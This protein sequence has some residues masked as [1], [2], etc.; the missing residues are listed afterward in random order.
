[1]NNQIIFIN[2]DIIIDSGGE[3]ILNNSSIVFTSSE[4]KN[5]IEVRSG[6]LLKLDNNS[7]V[8]SSISENNYYIKINR[9]GVFHSNNSEINYAGF[10]FGFDYTK[11]GVWINSDNTS[12]ENTYFKSNYMGIYL[13][14]TNNTSITNCSFYENYIGAYFSSSSNISIVNSKIS[15]SKNA[16]AIIKSS[17]SVNF[18]NMIIRDN[19]GEVL[20]TDSH[21]ITFYKSTIEHNNGGVRL[22]NI[23]GVL[24]LKNQVTRNNDGINI[25]DS[26]KIIIQ[27]NIITQNEGFAVYLINSLNCTIMRNTLKS[28]Q[29]GFSF[30]GIQNLEVVGNALLN[31]SFVFVNYTKETFASVQFNSSN[32]INGLPI[33]MIFNLNDSKVHNLTAGQLFIMFSN[34]ITIVSSNITGIEIYK[35]SEIIILES[36]TSKSDYGAYI[37]RS[38][39]VTLSESYF[40]DNYIGIYLAFDNTTQ[41]RNNTIRNNYHYGIFHKKSNNTIAYLNFFLDNLHHIHDDTAIFWDNTTIGNY[42]DDYTGIDKNNDGIG[43]VAYT[44]DSDSED[45]F[46]IV[47]PD[48]LSPEINSITQYPENP[49][50]L[51]D[52]R[53]EASI[54]D[55]A[56]VKVVILSLTNSSTWVN[57]SMN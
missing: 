25:R 40:E 20:A 37:R 32:I 10:A 35:A 36:A 15:K 16:G 12:M 21:N 11:S 43:D 2:S 3:L 4:L 52:V 18:N 13:E 27:E 9:Y 6:G 46:P 17:E 41:I 38:H 42:W 47:L 22:E 23:S 44:I 26:N 14:S 51:D 30:D 1:M 7:I 53:I 50:E 19:G 48:T 57:I 54:T 55:N 39:N 28:N 29:H 56:G 33:Y 45:Q 5:R 34:N 24:L 49:N 8:T 31:D